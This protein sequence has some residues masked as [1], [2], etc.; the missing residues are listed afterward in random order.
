MTTT[1]GLTEKTRKKLKETVDK[2]RTKLIDD[3]YLEANRKFSFDIKDRSRIRLSPEVVYQ[4]KLLSNWCNDPIRKSK[5]FTTNVKDLIKEFAYTLTNRLFILRQMEARGLQSLL[6][7]TG[8]KESTG[9]KEFREFCTELCHG[10]DEGY[11]F[12]LKQ[13]FDKIALDLPA[14]FSH[15]GILNI[16]DI[17]G[18]TLFWLVE[19]LNQKELAGAWTDDTT[20]GWLYQYWNDPD[21]ESVDNKILGIGTEKGKVETH[22]IAHKTQIFTERYMVEWLLQNSLGAQWL[23]ICKKNNW[24]PEA[25]NTIETLEA[26]REDWLTKLKNKEVFEDMPMPIESEEEERWKFYIKQEIPQEVIDSAPNSLKEVKVLDPACGSGHF[27]VYAFDL[28]YSFYQEEAKF[29]STNS[30]TIS[31]DEIVNNILSYN[32]H[33]IDIDPRAVQLAS[34]ALYLKAKEKSPSFQISKINLVATDLGLSNLKNDDPSI[35][36][37]VDELEKENIT[38]DD[39]MKIIESLKGAEYLGSLL[40][41][42]KTLSD[43]KSDMPLFQLQE[44]NTETHKSIDEK[45]IS[46]LKNFVLKH[47]KDDDLGVRTRAEQLT[48][49]LRLLELLGQKYEVICANPPYLALAK[50]EDK[51]GEKIQANYKDF[52]SDLYSIFIVRYTELLKENGFASFVTMRNW[53]FISQF[54]KLRDYV[55][56]NTRITTIA[57]LGVSAFVDMASS[58]HLSVSLYVFF[59]SNLNDIE[60]KIIK[61]IPTKEAKKDTKQMFKYINRLEKHSKKF[62][63]KQSKF[64]EIEGSPM[65]YWWSEEFRQVYLRSPKIGEVGIAKVGLS[66]SSN[67]RFIRTL[68]EINLNKI[69]VFNNKNHKWVPYVMGAE[70]KRWFES[71]TYCL[72]YKENGKEKFI[73]YKSLG[74]GGSENPYR[75]YF[76]KQGISYSYIGT[77]GFQCRIHKYLSAFDVSG[78]SIFV[79]DIN[80]TQIILSSEISGYVSQSINPTINNQVTDI[81]YIPIFDIIP[82]W[83]KYYDKAESLYDNY[84]ASHETCI[85]YAYQDLDKENFEASEILIRTAI[86]NEIYA[87]FS[88]ETV[89]TIKEE[90]GESTGNYKKFT[91]EELEKAHELYPNFADIY[92]NGPYKYEFGEIVTK[93]DGTPDRGGL[94]SLEDLCH[95]FQLHPESIIALRKHLGIIRKNDRQ[96]EAYRHLAWSLGVALGRFDAQT[97][98]L[99]STTLNDP[100]TLSEPDSNAP[101]SLDHGMFFVTDRGHIEELEDELKN[102][103]NNVINYLKDILIY[104]HGKEKAETIWEEIK[105]ALVYDCKSEITSKDRQKLNFNQFLRE[106][107]FDFHKSVYENRA[108][109]FP[110]SSNKKSYVVWCNIHKWTDSTLQTILAEFL[111]PEQKQLTMKLDSMRQTKVQTTDKSTIN[112][113]EKSITQ[114]D[115]WKDEID[116]F[117]NLVSQIAEKGANPEKQE[118][119]M[120]FIMDLDDGVMINSAGLYQ[121]LLPQ[122]KEPKKWWEHLEKPV[123][124]N[125]YDWSHM[126]MRYFTNRVWKKLEK[127]PSLAVA[128]SDYGDF[129]GRDLFKE[130]HPKMAEKWEQ[131]QSKI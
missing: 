17:S 21:R 41:I 69:K 78:A 68:S 115:N 122:W 129:L 13:V 118:R 47:D 27:L 95:E 38:R 93:K 4:Y 88:P 97:G 23:A 39:S 85:E 15:D 82:D 71:L 36:E 18:P 42:D 123:G 64:S 14:F 66:T 111:I 104:K 34:A 8:G 87:Q 55:L 19:Q 120:P 72:N 76:F 48:K 54:Q 75:S 92:L 108:I 6:V 44:D 102:K 24:T 2:I 53:M 50:I 81:K 46:S 109:Y 56:K 119:T 7:L 37:F 12:L 20:I 103:D 91:Q 80:K 1:A 128:H 51:I 126:A 45:F 98:G 61:P 59:K 63:F 110:L 31:I 30:A 89:A 112:E 25:I 105:N 70:G 94:Q 124:K 26:R 33:G 40:Q 96:D 28:L 65:I 130:L 113:L 117:I 100:T 32:L 106:K 10:S 79:P 5:D 22:E 49:G 67:S 57:D 131:E 11:N 52:K 35:L 74:G 90:V 101:K 77:S 107:C 9:Y 121:L 86:D 60:T 125:D 127:D 3:L 116:E 43:I 62:T 84:F 16:F 99:I 58:S 114:Y 29:T 73:H 83:K